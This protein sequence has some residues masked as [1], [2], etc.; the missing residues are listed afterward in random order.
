MPS[1]AVVTSTSPSIQLISA[2][3]FAVRSESCRCERRSAR[4][5]AASWRAGENRTPNVSS[6]ALH[7]GRPCELLG[8]I[9]DELVERRHE[10][11]R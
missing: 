11:S 10:A 8:E 9:R 4:R 7:P 2:G 6:S 3:S 1:V 5:R